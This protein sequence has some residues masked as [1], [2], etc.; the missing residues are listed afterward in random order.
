MAT[1]AS[2]ARR[3]RAL[4][5]D[6]R[7]ALAAGEIAVG[8]MLPP[9]RALAAKYR[10]SHAT[11][12]R[13]LEE[14]VDR[15][16]LR[17]VPRLGTFVARSM[18]VSEDLYLM[19]GPPADRPRVWPWLHQLAAGF[20]ERIAQLGGVSVLLPVDVAQDR[21]REGALPEVA[22]AFIFSLR[23]GEETG[24]ELS[25]DI[26]T[27]ES[28]SHSAPG[29]GE[30]TGVD[31]V[32]FDDVD[33]GR[34]AARHLFQLGCRRV[35][36]LGLHP[37]PGPDQ[38]YSWSWAREIGWAAE[39]R[40]AGHDPAGLV[41]APTREPTGFVDEHG[42]AAQAARELV[43]CADVDG[44]VCANDA[45]ALGLLKALREAGRA[46][47]SWPAIVGF[48]GLPE[49]KSVVLTSL[50]LPWD[51]LGRSAADLLSG[52]RTG[53]IT[54]PPQ[55]R[56]LP[57]TLIPRMSSWP[58]WLGRSEILEI[59][60]PAAKPGSPGERRGSARA[61][62]ISEPV[63]SPRARKVTGRVPDGGLGAK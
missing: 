18:S 19:L 52:R 31:V 16:F 26:P 13:Q 48:D 53:R 23:R 12:A 44:V 6:L 38:A 28:V 1:R 39:L 51:Q 5:D 45:S 32:N 17:S 63:A 40:E 14:L 46:H 3:R 47:S 41:F 37:R 60:Y 57:M 54:G 25:G 15:G 43:D 50:R 33:G 22:G 8:D 61:G 2:T 10:L 20:E 59:S 9:T 24:W 35:A 30:P 55:V 11:V 21:W 56:T 34:Q 58:A 4:A 36:F 29:T 27:V 49:T 42:S 62:R 7:E